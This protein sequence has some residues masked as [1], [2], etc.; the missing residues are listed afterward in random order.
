MQ[1]S[2]VAEEWVDH[3]FS[4]SPEV[5]SKLAHSDKDLA[6]AKKKYK[7]SLFHLAE[8][9][10]GYKNT[11]ATLWVFEKKAKELRVSL[12]K[13]ETQLAWDKEQIKLQQ[14]ELEGKDAEK[15]KAKQVVY[16]AGMTQTAQSLTAQLRDVARA[17]YLEV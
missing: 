13:T 5:E 12:K 1:V 16:D 10:R 17:L 6:E 11:E 14:K 7:D 15:A 4:K 8:V 9:E 3:A 2:F